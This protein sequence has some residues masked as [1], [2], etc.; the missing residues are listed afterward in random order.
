MKSLDWRPD[1]GQSPRKERQC[2]WTQAIRCLTRATIIT[3]SRQ[4]DLPLE[5]ECN[6]LLSSGSIGCPKA[7]TKINIYLDNKLDMAA[8][9]AYYLSGTLAP[10]AVTDTYAYPGMEKK[11]RSLQQE[12]TLQFHRRS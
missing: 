11:V 7:N 12:Y 6:V 8:S 9:Y 10:P 1:A 3:K 4:G 5:L 2:R